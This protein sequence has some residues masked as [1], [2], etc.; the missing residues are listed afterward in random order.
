MEVLTELHTKG[1][2]NSVGFDGGNI[3]EEEPK[4]TIYEINRYGTIIQNSL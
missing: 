2:L 1:I 3:S 4:G